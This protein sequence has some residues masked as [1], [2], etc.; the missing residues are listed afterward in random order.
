MKTRSDRL[1][2][3]NDRTGNQNGWLTG[4]ILTFTSCQA[5]EIDVKVPSTNFVIYYGYR[6]SLSLSCGITVDDFEYWYTF[7]NIDTHGIA[8][9]TGERNERTRNRWTDLVSIH[10][11]SKLT[12]T[13]SNACIKWF[14][15]QAAA[16]SS[17]I[18]DTREI[19]QYTITGGDSG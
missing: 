7:S 13:V 17:D 15:L 2:T 1:V 11:V 3:W 16:T 5:N 12:L 6:F 10:G 4:L 9:L 14:N 19:A 18:N 8:R